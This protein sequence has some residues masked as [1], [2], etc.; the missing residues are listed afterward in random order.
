MPLGSFHAD[1]FTAED[2]RILLEDQQASSTLDTLGPKEGKYFIGVNHN[3]KSYTER[4]R[5]MSD[6]TSSLNSSKT[7]RL[8]ALWGMG[9]TGKSQIA[10]RYAALHK[11]RFDPIIRIDAESLASA[12][13]S[14]QRA[15][16]VLGLPMPIYVT[17][18]LL[19]GNSHAP[20]NGTTLEQDW[21][22]KAVHDFLDSRHQEWLMII[23]NAD[24]LTWL[25]EII[26][27]GSMG[28]TI[29]TTR[30]RLVETMV[31]HTIKVDQMTTNEAY[32]LLLRGAQM[33]VSWMACN[34]ISGITPAEGTQKMEAIAIVRELGHLALAIDLAG[35]YI[36]Q[37]DQVKD[38]L[39]LFLEFYHQN[40]DK[41][42]IFAKHGTGIEGQYRRTVATVWETS[43]TALKKINLD[44]AELLLFFSYLNPASIEE[45][46]FSEA[47][48][49]QSSLL[50]SWSAVFSLITRALL[51]CGLAPLVVYGLCTFKLLGKKIKIPS[52][53]IS[54]GSHALLTVVIAIASEC[55]ATYAVRS[56][57]AQAYNTG[58]IVE[59]PG[60]LGWGAMI[61]LLYL[62]FNLSSEIFIAKKWKVEG[63]LLIEVPRT[64]KKF[65]ITLPSTERLIP[66]WTLLFLGPWVL[67]NEH[68]SID[69]RLEGYSTR[70][71][72]CLN[73][74]TINIQTLTGIMNGVHQSEIDGKQSLGS[75]F[76]HF[77][78]GRI[79]LVFVLLVL[80]EPWVAF[81]ER[82]QASTE[83]WDRELIPRFTSSTP[84]AATQESNR[85]LE[86]DEHYA[87]GIAC[88]I[89]LEFDHEY[90]RSSCEVKSTAVA[91][92][93]SKMKLAR[94]AL[95]QLLR[96][97]THPYGCAVIFTVLVALTSWPINIKTTEMWTSWPTQAIG[98]SYEIPE[99]LLGI[100]PAG[101]WNSQEFVA[102]IEP[103]RRLG[104]IQRA[105]EGTHEKG[106]T[107]SP[108]IQWWARNRM[109]EQGNK[110]LVHKVSYFLEKIY[111]SS[112]CWEDLSCQRMLGPHL[113]AVTTVGVHRNELAFVEIQRL[114]EMLYRT[115]RRIR[116]GI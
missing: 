114:L 14:Y 65:S 24:D 92:P 77:V 82:N 80:Y 45:R 32:E 51:C 40:A 20:E 21:V 54:P 73:F 94:G 5:I 110:V 68:W 85:L 30:D 91:G 41:M 75:M 62:G 18:S 10:L 58:D 47:S 56:S 8:V 105:C 99:K 78:F 74:T 11:H 15:F 61:M 22:I 1:L 76:S 28:S 71:L 29:I 19:K 33:N 50:G 79:L 97:I 16:D 36:S 48:M 107:I 49:A 72:N 90:R 12:A 98:A 43:Y 26:P 39:T 103:L 57:K 53:R 106:Y 60:S 86:N 35:H 66:T 23:D 108:M 6:L 4:L 95:F 55:V 116:D 25:D 44:S 96:P 63:N 46:L 109:C 84:D 17:D 27:R 112:R 113:V 7:S 52:Q 104:L 37:N 93:K 89:Q 67:K 102:T 69:P 111:Y 9:G 88:E 115:L 59:P 13:K 81:V 38:N 70:V 2:E 42:S 31:D 101:S 83:L 64:Q 87:R 3:V 34:T 100:T